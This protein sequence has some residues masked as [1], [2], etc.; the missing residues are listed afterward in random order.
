VAAPT[1]SRTPNWH[2]AKN[3]SH[4]SADGRVATEAAWPNGQRGK[5]KREQITLDRDRPSHGRTYELGYLL[6]S[7]QNAMRIDGGRFDSLS[8]RQRASGSLFRLEKRRNQFRDA[9]IPPRRKKISSVGIFAVILQVSVC[10]H[11]DSAKPLSCS[12]MTRYG[13]LKLSCLLRVMD[14]AES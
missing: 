5:A 2:R 1:G 11:V 9:Q 4:K 12:T 14:K 10:F 13:A 7:K 6:K 8:A 3:R